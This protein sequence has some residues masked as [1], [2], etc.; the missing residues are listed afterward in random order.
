MRTLELILLTLMPLVAVGG[1]SVM[2][3]MKEADIPSVRMA[4]IM[5]V[6]GLCL[7]IGIPFGALVAAIANG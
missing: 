4:L 6:W 7:V 3:T 2:F 1:L 5:K